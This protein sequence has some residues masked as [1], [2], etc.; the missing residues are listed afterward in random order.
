MPRSSFLTLL[1]LLAASALAATT[2]LSLGYGTQLNALANSRFNAN[3]HKTFFNQ[4][5][6]PLTGYSGTQLYNSNWSLGGTDANAYPL[7][8]LP[9]L[10]V[11]TDFKGPG[12]PAS[13]W[14]LFVSLSG[15][16]PQTSAYYLGTGELKETNVCSGVD[17]TKCPLAALGMVTSSGTAFYDVEV[18]SSLRFFNLNTG[19][20]YAF[21]LGGWAGGDLSLLA[22][23]GLAFQSFSLSSQFLASRCTTGSS[24]PCNNI[25]QLR[26]V[27]GELKSTSLYAVGP[28]LGA[29]LRYE[30]PAAFWFAE[31][32]ANVTV[33]YMRLENTGYVNFLAGGTSALARSSAEMGV[34]NAEDMTLI[35]PAVLVRMGVRL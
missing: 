4:G 1:V 29:T 19:M 30:R 35:L 25:N 13:P 10:R 12:A 26:V 6:V 22:E 3:L 15:I 20:S 16:L 14:G 11:T 24:I 2:R 32:A 23:L 5:A 17:Y 33:L 31:V 18:R 34:A 7:V 27:Q 21:G 8:H 28:V 9:E